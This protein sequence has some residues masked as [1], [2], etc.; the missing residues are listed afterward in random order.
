MA[1]HQYDSAELEACCRAPPS[2]ELHGG[3]CF[4][5]L[6][7]EPSSMTTVAPVV[8]NLPATAREAV[9]TALIPGSG[10]SPGG[11]LGSPLQYY[12]LE[13]SMERGAWWATV[14]GVT[15]SQTRSSD[16]ADTLRPH[17]SLQQTLAFIQFHTEEAEGEKKEWSSVSSSLDN[18]E[19]KQ[20]QEWAL[21]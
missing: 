7:L 9:D 15:K 18:L 10:K 19:Y 21:P 1:E 4:S 11:Q 14:P 6:I 17:L 13:N 3:M 2:S 12:C 16:W 20:L 5:F 8:K